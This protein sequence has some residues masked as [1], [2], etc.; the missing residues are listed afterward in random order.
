M[1]EVWSLLEEENT[2]VYNASEDTEVVWQY[3][4]SDD[5]EWKNMDK[6]YSQLHEHQYQQNVALFEYDVQ[7]AGGT[8]NYHYSTSLE[9]MIQTNT[10]T[11]RERKIRRKMI[12]VTEG[13]KQ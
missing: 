7:Y 6:I 8:K 5:T 13:A 9:T 4:S 3:R 1:H 10:N 12:I 2:V 11:H